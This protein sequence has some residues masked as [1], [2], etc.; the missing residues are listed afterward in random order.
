MCAYV[1]NTKQRIVDT[2]HTTEG[3]A[4][5]DG[6]TVEKGPVSTP[7]SRLPGNTQVTYYHHILI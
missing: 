7:L 1:T 3:V 4:K 6:M 2:H 5:K